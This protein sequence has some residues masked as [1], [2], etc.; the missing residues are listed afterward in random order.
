ATLPA[1]WDPLQPRAVVL[2]N[3]FRDQLDRYGEIDI[4]AG[5]WRAVLDGRPPGETVVIFNADDPLVSDVGAKFAG[6][7]VPFGIADASCPASITCTTSWRPR[8]AVCSWA[9]P[10]RRW[11][12]G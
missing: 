5:R 3:L 6:T 12:A 2:T 9:C 10:C 4:V 7:T 1:V 11:R 8:R